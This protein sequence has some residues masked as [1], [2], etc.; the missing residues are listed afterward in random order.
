MN[1]C[2]LN[3]KEYEISQKRI[4]DYI[5]TWSHKFTNDEK[6]KIVN[7]VCFRMDSLELDGCDFQEWNCIE[8]AYTDAACCY[9]FT[10]NFSVQAL[11]DEEDDLEIFDCMGLGKPEPEIE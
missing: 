7:E 5:D 9:I 8:D 1:I 10:H 11:L 4:L 2:Y 6:E 3:G